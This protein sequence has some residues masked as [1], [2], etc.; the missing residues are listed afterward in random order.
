[1][2]PLCHFEPKP[3][4]R[5]TLLPSS[6]VIRFSTNLIKSILILLGIASPEDS[7]GQAMSNRICRWNYETPTHSGNLAVLP[8]F[9]YRYGLVHFSIPSMFDIQLRGLESSGRQVDKLAA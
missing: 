5:L 6:V 2:I 3:Y 9:Q 7:Q 1:M 4:C 8:R